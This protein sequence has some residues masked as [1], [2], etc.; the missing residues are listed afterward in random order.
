MTNQN[1]M[2]SEIDK[3]YFIANIMTILSVSFSIIIISLSIISY[4][5][6]ELDHF[7]VG[8]FSFAL[9][10]I[11]TFEYYFVIKWL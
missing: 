3:T 4:L 8:I 1:E 9:A 5:I 11:I 10:S 6:T 2:K 7:L